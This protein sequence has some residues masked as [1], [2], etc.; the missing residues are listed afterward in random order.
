[1]NNSGGGNNDSTR[2]SP[3]TTPNRGVSAQHK[4]RT[5][6]RMH[7]QSSPEC[8]LILHINGPRSEY[9]RPKQTAITES[10]SSPS[11][12]SRAT[13]GSSALQAAQRVLLSSRLCNT[14]AGSLPPV[15]SAVY[16][17]Q[18]PVE[19]N[20]KDEKMDRDDDHHRVLVTFASSEDMMKVK[21]AVENAGVGSTEAYR[22]PVVRGQ[23]STTIW[24]HS[25]H[26]TSL[27][28]EL[29][30]RVPAATFTLAPFDKQGLGRTIFFQIPARSEIQLLDVP[31][32]WSGLSCRVGLMVKVRDRHQPSETACRRCFSR[33]HLVGSCPI[34]RASAPCAAC[35]QT[36]HQSQE[37]SMPIENRRCLVC[38]EVHPTLRCTSIS[39]KLCSL[40]RNRLHQIKEKSLSKSLHGHAHAAAQ[41]RPT[42]T[43]HS[44]STASMADSS[45]SSYASTVSLTDSSVSSNTYASAVLRGGGTATYPHDTSLQADLQA[46]NKALWDAIS[47]LRTELQA[48][49]EIDERMH[50]RFAEER[51][52]WTTALTE[53]ISM[54]KGLN[55]EITKLTANV[56]VVPPAVVQ[57]STSTTNSSG[58]RQRVSEDSS[59]ANRVR[60]SPSPPS[61]SPV[62]SSC[63]ASQ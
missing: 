51:K 45:A 63:Q 14:V 40:D 7:I 31:R 32:E 20:G 5:M 61:A 56:V 55:Q 59:N 58:K 12:A 41:D 57:Q 44:G 62:P 43:M 26:M 11:I 53:V 33:Q 46:Q 15:L 16:L 9:L 3:P 27:L 13:G 36:G 48:R 42:S 10:S 39:P 8:S 50:S 47:S 22:D 6:S 1:M 37:C 60:S 24:L 34:D 30:Q 21:C 35:G 23:V 29:Q 17:P 2:S 4:H 19:V 25:S 49:K 52:A 28:S 38:E 54:V 18:R